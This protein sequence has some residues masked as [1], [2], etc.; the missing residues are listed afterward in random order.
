MIQHAA[1]VLRV[2]LP[3][4]GFLGSG[5][6]TLVKHILEQP[7][8]LRIA[9]IVNEYGESVEGSFVQTADVSDICMARFSAQLCWRCER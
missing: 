2:D 5:K 4:A 9:V 7:H 3:F 8:G 6:S 1:Q